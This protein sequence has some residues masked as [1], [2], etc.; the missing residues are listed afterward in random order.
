[1]SRLPREFDSSM[2]PPRITAEEMTL[3][4]GDGSCFCPLTKQE[5]DT[6]SVVCST[7]ALRD[8]RANVY[9]DQFGAALPVLALRY[10]VRDLRERLISV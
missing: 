10:G 4:K 3:R 8:S 2:Q 9:D 7:D 6:F 1:M 5:T